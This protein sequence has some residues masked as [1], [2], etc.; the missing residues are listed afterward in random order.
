MKVLLSPAS[1]TVPLLVWVHV[2][3][4][5]FGHKLGHSLRLVFLTTAHALAELRVDQ[6]CSLNGLKDRKKS[7]YYTRTIFAILENGSKGYL[8]SQ[9][10]VKT[11]DD[12]SVPR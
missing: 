4:A 10:E 9:L 7:N 3:G 12:G 8:L 2:P 1:M 6:L 5:L 11:W